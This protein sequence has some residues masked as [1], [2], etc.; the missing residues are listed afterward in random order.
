[1]SQQANATLNRTNRFAN[2]WLL[3][4]MSVLGL[5][6]ILTATLVAWP[7]VSYISSRLF[8]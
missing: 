3:S 8:G 4:L 1:M 6:V 5:T 2:L 7:L